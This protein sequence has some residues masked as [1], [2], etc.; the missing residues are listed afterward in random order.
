MRPP[1][2]A[3]VEDAM[4]Q[5]MSQ[6]RKYSMLQLGDFRKVEYAAF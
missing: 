3:Q 6:M 1:P 5:L 4:T 2:R